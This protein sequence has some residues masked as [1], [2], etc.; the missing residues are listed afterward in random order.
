L[1]RSSF[2]VGDG[3]V[4]QATASFGLAEVDAHL[5]V[6]ASLDRADKALYTAK[7]AGRDCS[8]VWDGTP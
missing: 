1:A 4:L 8:R 3:I 6:E 2:S 7:A 5:P